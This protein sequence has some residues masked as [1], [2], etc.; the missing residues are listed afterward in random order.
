MQATS[1][2]SGSVSKSLAP[3]K[4]DLPENMSWFTYKRPP[5]PLDA[6]SRVMLCLA[7]LEHVRS[8]SC[9]VTGKKDKSEIREDW[10]LDL[11]F[12]RMGSLLQ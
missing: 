11:H 1:Q 4:T 3:V 6:E 8:L 5:L 9:D 2:N 7:G 12:C 10:E